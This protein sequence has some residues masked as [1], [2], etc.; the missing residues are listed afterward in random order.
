M[1]LFHKLFLS[2]VKRLGR[3]HEASLM[4]LYMPLSGSLFSY[5]P[6]GLKMIVKGKIPLLPHRIK[7]RDEVEKIFERSG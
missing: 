7:G 2:I 4:A 6:I 5:L 1:L 3:M